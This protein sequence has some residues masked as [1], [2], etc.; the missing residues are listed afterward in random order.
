MTGLKVKWHIKSLGYI[1]SDVTQCQS[2]SKSKLR[3]DI[4]TFT[5]NTILKKLNCKHVKTVFIHTGTIVWHIM[6]CTVDEDRYWTISSCQCL[7]TLQKNKHKSRWLMITSC[8]TVKLCPWHMCPSPCGTLSWQHPPFSAQV[9]GLTYLH[10]HDC[11][12]DMVSI[13]TT[14]SHTLMWTCTTENLWLDILYRI[15]KSIYQVCMSSTV[16]TAKNRMYVT[17]TYASYLIH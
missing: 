15:I 17:Q 12:M 13:E 8:V 16:K 2:K 3:S 11:E 1:S 5:K 7:S 9:R 6:L 10:I 4:T 14:L